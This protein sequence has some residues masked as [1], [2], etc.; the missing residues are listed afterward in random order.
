MEELSLTNPAHREMYR[1]GRRDVILQLING[2]TVCEH[3]PERLRALWNLYDYIASD[4]RPIPVAEV[5][6][7]IHGIL[8]GRE[9]PK[10]W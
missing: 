8:T 9:V 3:V 10:L 4:K 6:A 1:M 2:L 5:A 7:Q